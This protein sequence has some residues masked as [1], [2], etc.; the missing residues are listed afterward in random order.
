M[1]KKYVKIL[2]YFLQA[3]CVKNVQRQ[4]SKLNA[5]YLFY[6]AY[7]MASRMSSLNTFA[8]WASKYSS[9]ADLKAWLQAEEPSVEVVEFEGS[10]Y[11]ILKSGK[12]QASKEAAIAEDSKSEAAQLCR[13]VV[14]DTKANRPCSIAPFAA[15]R[16]QKIPMGEP[17]RLED[18]V[19]GVMVNV[20]RVKGDD[21]THV[22]TRSRLDADGTFYSE[23]TFRELFEEAMEAKEMCLDDIEAVMGDPSKMEDVHATFVSLVLAHPE[24]RVV[25]SVEKANFWAIYRGVV[26]EDGTLDFFTEDLPAAWRPKTYSLNFK[27]GEWSDLKAKFEEI[28]ASKPWYWQ[29]IAV[30]TGL[31]RWRFRNADHDRVRRDLRGTES[32]AFGRFLRLRAEKRVQEYLRVYTEDNEAFQGF[33]QEYRAATKALYTWYCRCHK[34]HLLP[35]KEMPKSVQPLVFGLHKHYLEELRPENKTLRM[36]ET[37][38]WITAHLKSQYGVPNLLRF[39]KET[40]QPPESKSEFQPR[41]PY[42][43]RVAY[44]EK[45]CQIR[46]ESEEEGEAATACGGG[47]GASAS[48]SAACEGCECGVEAPLEAP[49]ARP[50]VTAGGR[51]RGGR[52]RGRGGRATANGDRLSTPRSA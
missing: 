52:G 34:E 12:E 1:C 25:R 28:K 42:A 6:I 48:A 7:Q 37:I 32:N 50:T 4:L 39:A 40:V 51:G 13:S 10:P 49:V 33:E 24:H 45:V 5:T 2:Q 21:T 31:Q 26:R 18:F 41:A 22:T 23:R 44:E 19:E 16:D 35:F 46:D 3:K 36:A 9:W 11:V 47:G 38:E 15:R 30:H 27:A 8:S 43:G 17:L 20:F 14:W 29:G